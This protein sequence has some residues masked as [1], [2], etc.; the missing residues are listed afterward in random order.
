MKKGIKP[1]TKNLAIAAA[2]GY[3]DEDRKALYQYADSVSK[4]RNE[5]LYDLPFRTNPESVT[6]P[7]GLQPGQTFY[8][9]GDIPYVVN[10]DGT[11]S[12]YSFLT[13][14]KNAYNRNIQAQYALRRGETL[15]T[16]NTNN[17][18]SRANGNYGISPLYFAP[19]TTDYLDIVKTQLPSDYYDWNSIKSWKDGTWWRR[20]Y[21]GKSTQVKQTTANTGNKAKV[22]TNMKTKS[23]ENPPTSYKPILNAG[24]GPGGKLSDKPN[25]KV[26]ASGELNP[27]YTERRS[28]PVEVPEHMKPKSKVNWAET[29]Y[30]RSTVLPPLLDRPKS[31]KVSAYV[32]HAIM[33]PTEYNIDPILAEAAL[34]NSV[35][36]YNQANINP[37]TG[38]NM[39]FGLQSGVQRNRAITN[40]YATKNNA[41][42]Q[43]AMQN[44][45][46][47]NNWSRDF[48]NAR[49]V[50]SVEQAQNDAAARNIAR[51][52]RANALQ[53]WG[54]ILRDSKSNRMNAAKLQSIMPL[55][56]DTMPTADY[57]E[58]IKLIA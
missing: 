48:A 46:I 53:N 22:S 55:L 12:K 47:Y 43:T 1:K 38:A 56:K 50:A 52:G 33:G 13:P 57:N 58:L 4:A 34:T 3:D 45:G 40:A 20:P 28:V 26:K 29:L 42:N 17:L 14:I 15:Q 32:P 44:A 41:E 49:H 21:L 31:E 25:L 19:N 9:N 54:Q 23:I 11:A 30:G 8:H 35:N 37:N 5:K 51:T 2:T 24:Y 10:A 27:K 18:T 39:A 36:R 7:E 16:T 6:A